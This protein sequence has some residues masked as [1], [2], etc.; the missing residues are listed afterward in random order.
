MANSNNQDGSIDKLAGTYSGNKPEQKPEQ[1][2]VLYAFSPQ[3]FMDT[4]FKKVKVKEPTDTPVMYILEPNSS[5]YDFFR[6][7]Y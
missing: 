1:K 7:L 4:F 2:N 3:Q 5:A 6:K